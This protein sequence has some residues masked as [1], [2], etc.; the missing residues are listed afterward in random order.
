MRTLYHYLCQLFKRKHAPHRAVEKCLPPEALAAVQK[1][2]AFLRARHGVDVKPLA[3][4]E[5]A[6][7][8]RAADDRIEAIF[9]PL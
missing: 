5:K 2:A 8:P 4:E 7:K 3:P 6:G 9:P 1:E